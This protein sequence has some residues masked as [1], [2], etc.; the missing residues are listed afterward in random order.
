MRI[1][2]LIILILMFVGKLQAQF[3]YGSQ[4]EFGKNRVQYQPFNWTYYGFDRYQVYL[5]EGGQELAQYVAKRTEI[6]L[7]TIERKLDFQFEDK[8]QVLVYTN[9]GDFRQSNIGLSS[10]ENGNLGGVTKI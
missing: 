4:Q 8:L 3:Y 6:E 10:E 5:Y 7:E 9:Q 2:F 1:S